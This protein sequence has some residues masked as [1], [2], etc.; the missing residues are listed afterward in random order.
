MTDKEFL[1]VF[2]LPPKEAIELLK[3][4][5][6][7]TA[8]TDW[9]D[10]L[11]LSQQEAFAVSGVARLDILQ[12]FKIEILKAMESGQ[13]LK[14]FKDGMTAMFERKG[15]LGEAEEL[16]LTQPNRL[17]VIFETN[18]NQTFNAARYD[19]QA[20]LA[21]KLKKK[22]LQQYL[23]YK[24][25]ITKGT[26]DICKYLNGIAVKENDPI[27]NYIYPMNHFGC[28]S[29]VVML[30]YSLAK[31]YKV[32]TGAQVRSEMAVRGLKPAK[33]FGKRPGAPFTPDE[34]DYDKD[35]FNQYE[36]EN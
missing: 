30:P 14:Q 19:Q 18:V 13:G 3:K 26:T 11:A 36:K 33:G 25:I 22:G 23:V 27:W 12:D 15:W 6:K 29:R 7:Y 5:W 35:L 2:D 31:G 10:Y 28:R 24:S 8:T 34:S 4:K 1:A 20:E 9:E 21:K 32:K 17:K 16:G